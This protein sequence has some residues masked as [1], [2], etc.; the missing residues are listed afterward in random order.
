MKKILIIDANPSKF[1]YTSCLAEEYEINAKEK[2]YKAVCGVDEAGRGPLCGP[3]TFL[4]NFFW[5]FRIRY[6]KFIYIFSP[7]DDL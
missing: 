5:T 6:G 2:G 4:H 3:L 1:S 7:G